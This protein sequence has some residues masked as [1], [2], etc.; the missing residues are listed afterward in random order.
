MSSYAAAAM[1]TSAGITEKASKTI[2][3]H[4]RH[5]FGATVQVPMKHIKE[6]GS[7]YVKPKFGTYELKDKNNPRKKKEEISYWVNDIADVIA[8]DMSRILKTRDNH[9]YGYPSKVRNN[10]IGC[11]VVL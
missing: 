6:I 4:L 5:E 2:V 3:W 1:L 7:G 8:T 11:D 9:T 10:E